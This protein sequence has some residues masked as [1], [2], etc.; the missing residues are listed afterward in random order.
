MKH[1]W[2]AQQ[3]SCLNFK[4]FTLLQATRGDIQ[5]ESLNG[6]RAIAS[7]WTPD[8]H[9]AQAVCAAGNLLIMSHDENRN[10]QKYMDQRMFRNLEMNQEKA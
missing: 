9:W 5:L 7:L 10:K 3:L 4:C 1:S 6:S 2:K 8:K